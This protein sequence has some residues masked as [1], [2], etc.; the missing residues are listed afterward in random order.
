MLDGKLS[1]SHNPSI[2]V[3]NSKILSSKT[4]M[5]VAGKR[6]N[7]NNTYNR[8]VNFS[9]ARE[10][11]KL[12]GLRI[13]PF[14]VFVFSFVCFF[15]YWSLFTLAFF[16]PPII[17]FLSEKC[18]TNYHNIKMFDLTF[19]RH[20]FIRYTISV[21][22]AYKPIR[23]EMCECVCGLAHAIPFVLFIRISLIQ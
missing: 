10:K 9:S 16:Q 18:F 14:S 5:N 3:S 23:F 8:L 15:F 2:S 1:L 19:F 21:L 20:R 11:K 12:F 7:I 22:F 13:A 17:S 4:K 6:G